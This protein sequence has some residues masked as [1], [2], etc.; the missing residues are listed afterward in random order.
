MNT[1]RRRSTAA[2]A[3][4]ATAAATAMLLGG[5]AMSAHADGSEQLGPPSIPIA[6]GTGVAA[7]GTGL[8]TQPGTLDID[9]P[10][11]AEVT[12]VLL[13]WEGQHTSATTGADDT[14]VVDGVD[15]AGQLIG[16]PT[17][18]FSAGDGEHWSST[19]RAD[20]TDLDLVADGP[21]SLT[22]SGLEFDQINNGAGLTVLYDDGGTPAEISVADGSDLAYH[23]F[24]SP[25]DTTVPVVFNFASS[26]AARTVE[27]IL[28]ASSV[29]DA[30]SE[31]PNVIEVIVDGVAT[32]YPTLLSSDNGPEWDT[33]KVTVDVPAGV[34]QFSVQALSVDDEDTGRN[35][36]SFTWIAATAV[37]PAPVVP[38]TTTTQPPTTTTQPATT[39]TQPATT[40]TQPATT[41][42]Q[43]AT[44]TTQP[45]TTTTQPAT[46]TTQPATTTTVG[47]AGPTPTTLPPSNTTPDLTQL[48]ST[49][50]T[51]VIGQLLVALGATLFGAVLLGTTRRRSDRLS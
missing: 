6:S 18:F 9:V 8:F 31:R 1:I 42:T 43:P 33:V 40:T 19:Y 13:Y 4:A 28:F 35:P 46:T 47:Q 44:T 37:I 20:I 36:A 5:A 39:T 17:Y 10:S 22:V 3:W 16:G 50:S 29:Q 51:R 41:T 2:K 34:T 32:R 15:I 38:T 24:G 11:G 27:L 49:G 12:Q 21:N 45:A 30:V 7:N 48:P 23:E 14:I 26:E 25:L